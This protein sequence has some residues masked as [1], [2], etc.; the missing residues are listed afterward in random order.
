LSRF[1]IVEEPGKTAQDGIAISAWSRSQTENTCRNCSPKATR[2]AKGGDESARWGCFPQ[3]E[4][5]MRKTRK[6]VN[7]KI[8]QIVA[9]SSNEDAG[10]LF[11]ALSKVGGTNFRRAMR[12]VHRVHQETSQGRQMKSVCSGSISFMALRA[13]RF[14]NPNSV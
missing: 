5:E 11:K 10:Q 4:N 12:R 13:A 8:G 1:P 9:E 14:E 6:K 3:R 2:R 7:E